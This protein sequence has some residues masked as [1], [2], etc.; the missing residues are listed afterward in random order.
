MPQ[1][2]EQRTN[3]AK[4]Y[5]PEG[6]EKLIVDHLLK[7]I[8]VLKDTKKRILDN[9]NFEDV[10]EAA[11]REYQPHNLRDKGNK[12]S[13]M[14][15]QD[16]IKG[17]R[18]SRIVPIT[19][20]EGQEWRSDVS[21]PTLLAKIQTAIS[22]LVDQNPEATFKAVLKK[23]K[24]TT[25][26]AKAIWKRSW[27]LAD[28]KEQLKTFIF[29][30]AK[31]G[32][33]PAR[34]YP[35]IVQ[36][37][38]E[39]L[40]EL[41]VDHPENN[42]YKTITITEFNDIYREALDPWRTWID[43]M[44]NHYDP[45]SLD[46]WYFE[47]DFSRDSFDI[48]FGQYENSDKVTFGSRV[49]PESGSDDVNQETAQRDD[50]ITL[51][52]YE[53][54]K[55]D[56]YVIWAPQDNVVI[57]SSPLPNDDGLL[58][59]WDAIWNMRD[60]RTRYG[61]GLYEIMKNNK[62]MY[63]RLDNMDMDQ[64]VL[65][66]YTMLFYSGSNQLVGDG[67]VTVSPGVMKQKLP[68]TT[69][70]QVKID[71]SGK[72]REGAQM[73]MERIN[74]TTGIT[75]TL[76]GEV[77]GKTLG[78]VL[79]AKDSALKR[80]NIPLSNIASGLE[81]DAQLTLSW[82]NQVYSIPEVMEFVSEQDLKEFM[83][84]NDRQPSSTLQ[85]KD[86]SISADFPKV[87]E[88]SLDENQEKE[89]IESPDSRFFVIGS[90]I[91]KTALKWKGKITVSAQSIIAPTHELDRQRKLE[92]FN[93]VYPTVQSISMALQQGQFSL[94]LDL[95]KPVVQILEIQDEEP[96][97]W[98]P[99]M[100]VKLLN[101]PEMAKQMEEQAQQQAVAA[102]K[103]AQ[104]LF[105]DGNS[106]EAVKGAPAQGG[107]V[108]TPVSPQGQ[109]PETAKVVPTGQISNPVKDSMTEMGKVR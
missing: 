43:D 7:R 16:E 102:E 11:D 97:D 46:D 72:G 83:A 27:S 80:L 47:K 21:E 38:K 26:V 76:Q 93:M 66:I 1:L 30:L 63:D 81:K 86:G 2:L 84:E 25:A 4:A 109:G 68:G 8:P 44:A 89:L 51:G 85:K 6:E 3:S 29:N 107:G 71:Y 67:N 95:S 56:L 53:S 106:P 61:I 24:P 37:T 70:D 60:P 49:M 62:V 34:T 94:A 77:E 45:Y 79:H 5:S 57:Y 101:N 99:D 17:L 88:L 108:Q 92:L 15:V 28:S 42:K 87:L 74:E 9:L 52:F 36:R 19:G 96:E 10:M 105:V 20:Q 73:V 13:V 69:V 55:K 91:Q 12:G 64:L 18:G 32:W 75:P 35:R 50:I 103:E 39:I 90:D 78:E 100:A 58:S 59:L 82:A 23:Y 14:L 31:Y 40:T 48:E 54:K 41:D 33:A 65:S 22:I 98:L 104:P